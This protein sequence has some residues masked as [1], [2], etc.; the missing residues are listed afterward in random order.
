MAAA[1]RALAR[2]A[3]RALAVGLGAGV[4]ISAWNLVGM[5]T[6]IAI[7]A[8]VVGRQAF[9]LAALA[10]TAWAAGASLRGGSWARAA[11]LAILASASCAATVLATH[12]LSTAWG[13]ERIRQVP[14]FVLDY[15]R[16]AYTSPAAYFADHYWELL[17]LQGFTWIL[18]AAGMAVLGT[19][20]GRAGA[21][22]R[23]RAQPRSS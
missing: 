23:S 22:L 10:A 11:S 3:T 14:E 2:G 19:V 18:G 6:R 12:A 1:D 16:H 17:E 21:L 7:P 4:A 13:T 8:W 5:Y 20:L 15:T 9:F